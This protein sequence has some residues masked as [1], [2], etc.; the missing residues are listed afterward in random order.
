MRHGL[1]LNL[2]HWPKQIV[3][4]FRMFVWEV[5]AVTR[6]APKQKVNDYVSNICLYRI[7]LFV[8]IIVW[9]QPKT[10]K[11]ET[12]PIELVVNHGKPLSLMPPMW[13]YHLY[14]LSFDHGTNMCLR[15]ISIY[16]MVNIQLQTKPH[17]SVD[18]GWLFQ[19][20]FVSNLGT[21]LFY[22]PKI[23]KTNPKQ[24][25]ILYVSIFFGATK[26]S[27]FSL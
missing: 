24:W 16:S 25:Q 18:A 1:F 4:H 21:K 5:S 3:E 27:L 11:E 9:Q 15:S 12:H 10:D 22:P 6:N 19:D 7:K 17:G 14:H 8:H 20:H 13:L 2:P 26:K 23:E